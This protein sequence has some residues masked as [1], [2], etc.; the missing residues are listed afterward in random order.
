MWPECAAFGT[1]AMNPNTVLRSREV[2]ERVLTEA[3]IFFGKPTTI[4]VWSPIP[5]TS[6]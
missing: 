6:R 4:P 2:G 5:F 3:P 1:V